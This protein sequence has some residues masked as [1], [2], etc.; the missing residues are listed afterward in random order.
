M[1]CGV[2]CGTHTVHTR[3]SHQEKPLNHQSSEFCFSPALS[4]LYKQQGK[5]FGFYWCVLVSSGLGILS[6]RSSNLII[7]WS[8]TLTWLWYDILCVGGLTRRLPTPHSP[9]YQLTVS[10]W[11]VSLHCS[12]SQH[13]NH[14]SSSSQSPGQGQTVES[15]SPGQSRERIPDIGK[16]LQFRIKFHLFHLKFI[17]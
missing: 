14:L 4:F 1:W 6:N 3:W 17:E 16:S 9:V 8:L 15:N 12:R 7:R 11:S 13:T 5:S 2:V 10:C